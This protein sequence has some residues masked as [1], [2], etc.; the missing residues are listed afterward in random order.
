[1]I[2]TKIAL[3]TNFIFIPRGG[4]QAVRVSNDYEQRYLGQFN[5]FQI[6]T[7]VSDAI[8]L[9]SAGFEPKN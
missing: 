6:L 5:R 3:C 9:I 7:I 1:L 8:L 4:C 2:C